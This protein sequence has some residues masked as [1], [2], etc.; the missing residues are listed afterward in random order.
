MASRLASV[1][2]PVSPDTSRSLRPRLARGLIDQRDEGCEVGG[3]GAQLLGDDDL[4]RGIDRDL[5]VVAGDEPALARH[6]AA[7]AVGEVTLRLV[8][9]RVGGAVLAGP[10]APACQKMGR[11]R[12]GSVRPGPALASASSCALAARIR[13]RRRCLSA[14]QAGVSSPRLAPCWGVL[15]GVGGIGLV[16]PGRDLGG[17]FRF[18][19]HHMLVAHRLVLAGIR[20]ELGTVHSHVPQLDQPGRLAQPQHLDE[21]LLQRRQVS[22]AEVADGAENPAGS[23]R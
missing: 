14:I 19:A 12:R 11:V 10:A 18:L 8:R 4:V 16:Q 6:D 23:A 15:G 1:A 20:L 3:V 22:L 7:V 2:N 13:S 5:A 21:E 17:K 9:R